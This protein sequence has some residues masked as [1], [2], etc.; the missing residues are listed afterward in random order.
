MA[1]RQLAVTGCE[2]G[3]LDAQGDSLRE[4]SVRIARRIPHEAVTAPFLTRPGFVA[5]VF[6]IAG[7]GAGCRQPIL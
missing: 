1:V 6:S 2:L 7:P 3:G 5:T 4:Q